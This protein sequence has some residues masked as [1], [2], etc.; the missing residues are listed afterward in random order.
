[1]T[2]ATARRRRRRRLTPRRW[3]PFLALSALVVGAT[4]LEPELSTVDPAQLDSSLDRS[5]LPAVT[6]PDALST[7]WY[8]AG[9]T[10]AGSEGL[11]E[12]TI[13]LANDAPIGATADVTFLTAEGQAGEVETLSVPAHGRARVAAAE[14]VEAEWVGAVVEVH[15]GRVAVDREVIGSLG[16]DAAPCSTEAAD[17]WYVASGATVRGSEL[18]LSLFNPFADATSVDVTFATNTGRR[19]PRALRG[20]S[21]PGRSVRVVRV[22]EIVTDRST[23]AATVRARIGRVVVDRIQT[24]DGT[25]DAVTGEGEA[26]AATPA[27]KGLISTPA[28]PVRADRWVIP[29]GRVAEGVRT[30]IAVYNPGSAAAEVDVVVSYQDPQRYPSPAPIG[31]SVPARE[32]V[33]VD[34][35]DQPDVLAE[36][37]LWVD[38][39]SLEGVPVVAER[40]STFGDPSSRQGAAA[41]LGNPVAATRWLVTQ[42][43]PTRLRSGTVQ[44]VNPGST[45]ARVTVLTLADGDRRELTSA[46]VVVPAGDRRSLDLG[47]AARAASVVVASSEP[48]VVGSSLSLLDGFGISLQPA[49][50]FPE[51][52]VALPPLR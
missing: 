39:R 1:M 2:P 43:G 21:I 41:T 46:A 16:F 10:A 26:A 20:F 44:V 29:G 34:L 38:V 24:F 17:R 31:I 6:G 5:T 8:C 4:V 3:L 51:A 30:Q 18:Y 47:S 28:S 32:Q 45:E 40:V 50:A 33:I 25:G 52:V 15:G 19:A 48:V 36:T 9:G 13:L 35:N 23:V 11:A 37:D 49:F 12:L 42:A 27:P 22:G 14:R 7:A